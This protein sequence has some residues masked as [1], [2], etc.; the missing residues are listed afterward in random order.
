MC[1]YFASAVYF[2]CENHLMIFSLDIYILLV[3]RSDYVIVVFVER[4]VM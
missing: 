4:C 1:H 3:E 2:S